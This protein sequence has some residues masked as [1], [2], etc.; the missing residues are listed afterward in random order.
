MISLGNAASENK[1]TPEKNLAD[2]HFVV[3]DTYRQRQHIDSKIIQGLLARSYR[4]TDQLNG[5]YTLSTT[6]SLKQSLHRQQGVR[7]T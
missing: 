3:T 4:P 5:R 6:Q 7:R 1:A 2:M